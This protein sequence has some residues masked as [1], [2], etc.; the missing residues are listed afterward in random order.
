MKTF[1]KVLCFSLA[2]L[3]YVPMV[4]TGSALV[5]ENLRL[6]LH[7]KVTKA[8]QEG[9]PI[10]PEE[11]KLV[12]EMIDEILACVD[13]KMPGELEHIAELHPDEQGVEI[14][15]L[16]EQIKDRPLMLVYEILN[17]LKE[18]GKLEKLDESIGKIRDQEKKRIEELA[19]KRRQLELS[20]RRDL[21]AILAT[22]FMVVLLG[23]VI[24]SLS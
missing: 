11:L 2:M 3:L 8:I 21:V 16:M 19:E 4:N 15:R 12:L 18:S 23:Y 6:R 5:P 22:G 9:G 20:G 7:E 17:K 1:K 13:A 24:Y 10:E 14:Y